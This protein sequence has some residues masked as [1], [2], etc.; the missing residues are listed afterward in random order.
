MNISELEKLFIEESKH[1]GYQ[2]LSSRLSH[3]INIDKKYVKSRYEKERLKYIMENINIKNKT[4]LDIG[5][6]TGFFTF[7][8]IDNGAEKVCYYEGNKTHA[9]FVSGA[10]DIIGIRD[11]V[12]IKNEYFTFNKELSDRY[13]LVLLLNVLHHISDDYGDK[14]ISSIERAKDVILS[15][16]NSLSTIAETMVFQMGFNWKGNKELGLFQYGTKREMIDFVKEGTN[17]YWTIYKIGIAE[18]RNGLVEYHD[19]NDTNIIRCDSMG[20]FLNRPIFIMKSLKF[21]S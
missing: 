15:Q 18:Y 9:K 16:L 5:G 4:V 19:L 13:D 7:E 6:N 17:G 8:L 11:K 14:K 20:E 21:N 1:S 10:A 2:V 12:E 3:F